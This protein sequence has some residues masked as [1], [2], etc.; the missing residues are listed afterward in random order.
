MNSAIS[1]SSPNNRSP[2]P[3]DTGSFRCRFNSPQ[4]SS[5]PFERPIRRSGLTS[6]EF[7]GPSTAS[8]DEP[9]IEAGRST[10]T[11]VPLAGFLNLSAVSWQVRIPRPYFVPQPFLGFL[12]QSFP[13]QQVRSSLKDPNSLA[14]IH[15]RAE[16]TS[17][18]L[19]ATSF[20]NSHAETQLLG[21]PG[22]YRFPFRR[23]SRLPGPP[24]ER[25]ANRSFPLAS[26]T[27]EP[28][29][30]RLRSKHRSK[31]RPFDR[32]S[33]GLLPL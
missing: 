9:H 3:K 28:T 20:P 15:P 19:V 33:P 21:S 1:N 18:S 23:T 32:S 5:P 30:L 11:P 24:G 16:T 17:R 31:L 7:S 4:S 13:S 26:P 22:N 27:S 12:L 8:S 25:A 6:L 29:S 2:I 10:P 14:V